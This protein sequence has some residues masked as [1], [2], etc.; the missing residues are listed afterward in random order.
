MNIDRLIPHCGIFQSDDMLISLAPFSATQ[1]MEAKVKL[2][3][4]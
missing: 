1:Q 2:G 4:G 3:I